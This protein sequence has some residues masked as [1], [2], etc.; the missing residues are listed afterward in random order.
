MAKISQRQ[1]VA[2]VVPVATM[3]GHVTGPTFND[4]FA[5]VSGGEITAKVEKI[6]DGGKA[7]PETLCA[8]A[9]IGDI[10]ITRHYDPDRDGPSLKAARRLVGSAY[11]DVTIFD[12]NCSLVQYGTERVYPQS[13]L[14]GMK[15][16]DGDSSSGAP[17]TY[18]LTFSVATVS[19]ETN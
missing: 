5:Q 11:Y 18:S 19:G 3:A 14:V 9:E 15:E 17:T 12:L 8:P 13:L 6:Y 7:F 16:P 1:V 4:Y 2:K 10:T